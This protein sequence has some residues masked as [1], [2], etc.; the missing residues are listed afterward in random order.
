MVRVGA[1]RGERRLVRQVLVREDRGLAVLEHALHVGV[2]L[3]LLVHP[4]VVIAVLLVT[5][6]R[7]HV[8]ESVVGVLAGRDQHLS[9]PLALEVA[10][11]HAEQL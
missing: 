10:R 4:G 5:D 11:I 8:Y 2:L 1:L 9:M 6:D 7:R 3:H